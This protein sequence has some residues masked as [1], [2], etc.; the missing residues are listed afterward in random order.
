ML[1]STSK[2]LLFGASVLALVIA[3]ALLGSMDRS[4]IGEG[5]PPPSTSEAATL[6]PTES[7]S[8]AP[9]LEPSPSSGV[10]TVTLTVSLSGAENGVIQSSPAG[11]S[12]PS[13][14]TGV[15]PVGTVVTL[16]PLASPPPAGFETHFLGF[17]GGCTGTSCDIT[18][19]QSRT[20]AATF[21]QTAIYGTLTV[22]KAGPLP[23]D[24]FVSVWPPVFGSGINCGTTCSAEYAIGST[25]T[26]VV[27]LSPDVVFAGWSGPCSGTDACTITITGPITVIATTASP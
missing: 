12:C 13:D 6:S 24:I 4:P 5:S 14:C 27:A 26:L 22:E 2:T 21:S 11:I 9:S 19:N 15:F 8:L 18:L 16:T 7:A 10:E 1:R 25:V 20:V 3:V 17:S 23:E